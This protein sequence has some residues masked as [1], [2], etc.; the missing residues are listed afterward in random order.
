M[1]RGTSVVVSAYSKGRQEEGIIGAGHTPKP[2]VI[3]QRDLSVALQG[4]RHTYV[5]FNRDADGDRPASALWILKEDAY[6]GKTYNDAYAAGERCFVE[7]LV[8]GQEYN[9][10]LLD[11]PGTG[12]DFALGAI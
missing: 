2:G 1:A 7:T 4:G 11:I 12:D 5:P 6:Q 3:M 10:W 8:A 9:C